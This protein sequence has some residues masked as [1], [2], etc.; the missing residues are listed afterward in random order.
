MRRGYAKYLRGNLA[1]LTAQKT[2]VRSYS[3]GGVPNIFGAIQEDRHDIAA[4][5]DIIFFEYCVNDRHAI[6]IDHYSL[7]WAGKS[8]EGFI[9]K[10][11]KS[12]PHCLIVL[13]IFGVNKEEYYQQN[14]AVSELYESIGQH[15]RLPVINLTEILRQERGLDFIQSLYIG[16]DVAH[17]SRPDGVQIIAQTIAEQLEKTGIINR[18]KSDKNSSKG[19]GTQPVYQDNLENLSFFD[20]FSQGNFFKHQAKVS[21]YQNSVFREENHTLVQGN[22]LE[23]LLKGS[24]AALY[25]KSDLNDGLIEIKFDTEKIITSS[26]S[27]WVTKIRPNN[28]N[29]ITLPLRRFAPTTDFAPVSISCCQSYSDNFELDYIKQAPKKKNPQ[30]WRLNIIGIAY[31]GELKPLP[32]V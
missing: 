18:L 20:D 22:S 26:Y 27:E 1:E 25:I 11:Q 9:R 8:L 15:Y 21:V 13:L 4:Q 3:L 23:F 12:N 16:D 7:E 28:I 17:Y 10:C 6:E 14:C 31:V 32:Q 2:F 19:I 24:F 30:Q 29:L 5:S